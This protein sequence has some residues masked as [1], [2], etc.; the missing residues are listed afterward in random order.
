[1]DNKQLN[2]SVTRA[3]E[4]NENDPRFEITVIRW[5]R[6]LLAALVVIGLSALVVWSLLPSE[7]TA[8]ESAPETLF[9]LEDPSSPTIEQGMPEVI[10]SPLTAID[11]YAAVEAETADTSTPAP[12]D[13]ANLSTLDF[14]APTSEGAMTMRALP[15]DATAGHPLIST[16]P[17]VEQQTAP[18]HTQILSTRQPVTMAPAE[19]PVK[20]PTQV[21]S[22]RAST[23]DTTN[24]H[25]VKRIQL[26]SDVQKLAPVD[27]LESSLS[28]NERGLIKVFLF[29]ELNDLKG[30]KVSHVWYLNGKR[31]ARVNMGRLSTDSARIYS[32]KYIDKHMTGHWEVKVV[33]N[34]TNIIATKTFDVR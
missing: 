15:T 30:K 16:D 5:D 12:A 3:R 11:H 27:T 31:M 34:G 10:D 19:T 29:T 1:M 22:T 6:I 33:E 2:I 9:S 25:Y 26:T 4:F 20:S 18:A 17:A 28:M 32:S 23:T 7:E 24:K 13:S 14:S 21:L 8:P